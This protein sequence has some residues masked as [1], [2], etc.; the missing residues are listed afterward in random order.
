MD[1]K[2]KM[3]SQKQ[4]ILKWY[5]EDKISQREIAQRLQ[6]GKSTVERKITLDMLKPTKNNK[7]LVDCINFRKEF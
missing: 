3:E 4:Q 5:L 6:I 7:F 2:E 1:M